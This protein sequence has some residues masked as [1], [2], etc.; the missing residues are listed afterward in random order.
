MV[1]SGTSRH[2]AD[3]GPSTVSPLSATILGNHATTWTSYWLVWEVWNV[4]D[5][6]AE[7]V[8]ELQVNA[9]Q[10]ICRGGLP[11]LTALLPGLKVNSLPGH[12]CSAG[13]VCKALWV[14]TTYV[15]RRF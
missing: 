4:R 3:C 13:S 2:H 11:L 12:A 1:V 9:D 5:T 7:Q 8:P 6:G 14:P 15:S 10:G